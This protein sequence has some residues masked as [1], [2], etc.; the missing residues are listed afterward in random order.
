MNDP[1]GVFKQLLDFYIKYYESRFDLRHEPL[2][3]ER[4][5]LL[6]TDGYIF[7]EPYIEA[8]PSYVSSNQTLREATAALKLSPALADFAECGLF[9]SDFR[10]HQH[11][12]N[13]LISVQ[14]GRHVVITAGTG[15]GKTESF[16]LPI[17]ASLLAESRMWS[18]PKPS[19]PSAWWKDNSGFAPQRNYETRPAAIRALILYPMN[20]LVEDQMQRLRRALDGPRARQWLDKHRRGNRLY[21]GRYTGRTP[22]SGDTSNRTRLRQLREYLRRVSQTS[23]KVAADEERRYFFPQV[24]GAEMLSRWDMQVAPPDLLITNYSMLN[25]MLMRDIEQSMFETTRQWLAADPNH[26]FTL[27]VDELHLYRGTPGTE[28]ALLLRNLLL[29]LGLIDKPQQVR[30]I[31][32]S[33]SLTNDD[34][35]REYVSQFF[36]AQPN[37]F[38]II[39]GQRNL[40]STSAPPTLTEHVSAFAQFSQDAK[41]QD[42]FQPAARALVAKLSPTAVGEADV[43]MRLG[44]ALDAIGCVSALVNACVN[45][46]TNQLRTRSFME[47]VHSL[48]GSASDD[49]T[50]R[51]AMAGLLMALAEAKVNDAVTQEIRALLPVRA[52][53]FF[54]SVQGI[55]ACSDPKCSAVSPDFRTDDRPVGKLYMEPRIRCKCGAHVLDLLYC[56]T[57]GEVFLGGYK[58]EDPD[59]HGSWYLFPDVPELQNLPDMPQ[60]E[61]HF[62]NYALYWPSLHTP[63]DEEWNRQGLIFSFKRVKLDPSAARVSKDIAKATG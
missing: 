4:H 41:Q 42:N 39:P 25:V 17:V 30:F 10:L 9:P 59:N 50:I 28:V 61:K 7:R 6:L 27:V 57:C 58:S 31:A 1:Y 36:G 20:A 5:Q 37:A 48:F 21:F 15:S 56:Q 12:Y 54:R 44:H 29:R 60:L 38:D 11:Q 62:A 49:A 55:W 13:A 24:D 32:A 8:V 51:N 26:V 16:L 40:P 19:A 46:E 34:A 63:I 43:S 45:H 23:R 22:V 47:L 14:N 33:A 3:Q 35:G 52:H 53:Y 2:M 18:T